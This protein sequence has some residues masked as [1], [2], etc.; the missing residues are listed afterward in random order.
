MMKRIIGLFLTTLFFVLAFNSAQAENKV[1]LRIGDRYAIDNTYYVELWADVAPS[2]E[3]IFG[4]EEIYLTFNNLALDP[5]TYGYAW[6]G[7]PTDAQRIYE[8]D[9]DLTTSDYQPYFQAVLPSTPEFTTNQ[10]YFVWQTIANA[11]DMIVKTGSFKIGTFRFGIIN[12]SLLDNISIGGTGYSGTQEASFIV[13]GYDEMTYNCGNSTCWAKIDPTPQYI[14]PPSP[15]ITTGPTLTSI[16][17]GS[18]ISVPFTTPAE[19]N[20]ANV[21]TAQLSD[22]AGSFATPTTIG[23]LTGIGSATIDANIPAAT[24]AGIAY[25][26]R[27]VGSDPVNIGIDNGTD[28]TIGTYPEQ[29]DLVG[30]E[31]YCPG[32]TGVVLT[33][34]NSQTGVSY[35]LTQDGTNYGAAIDGTGANILWNNLLVGNYNVVATSTSGC[36]TNMTAEKIVTNYILPTEFTLN[37]TDGTTYCPGG[38]SLPLELMGSEVGVNYQLLNNGIEVGLPINGTGSN[39]IWNVFAGTYTVEAENVATGC[40]RLF[41]TVIEI[42]ENVLPLVFPVSASATSYCAN[43]DGVS[44]TLVGSEVDVEYS[45]MMGETIVGDIFLGD[46]QSHT[47]TGMTA[48]SYQVSGLN[49]T[50]TCSR[51]MNTTPLVIS[52]IPLPTATIN[53]PLQVIQNSQA[54]YSTP[55]INGAEYLWIVTGG[56]ISGASNTANITVNW[57]EI[58]Q[59][60]IS[61]TKT[62]N[63]CIDANTENINI[64]DFQVPSIQA[65]NMI[66]LGIT[67]TNLTARWTRGNGNANILVCYPGNVID[68]TPEIGTTY[69]VGQTIGSGTV[70]YV[71]TGR[72][73]SLT[74]LT[75]G[76]TYTFKAFEYLT[77]GYYLLTNA[78]FNPRSKNT[79]PAVPTLNT[80][81]NVTSNSVDLSWE[82]TGSLDYYE[83]E[84]ATDIAFTEIVNGWQGADLGDMSY[85]NVDELEGNTQYYYRVR[86]ISG[87][88]ASAWVSGTFSTT[89][90][91]PTILPT[92]MQFADITVQSMNL[93]WTAGNGQYYLVIASMNNTPV[94]SPVDGTVYTVGDLYDGGTII[95]NGA[96]LTALAADLDPATN[97]YYTVFTYNGAAAAANYNP[98][99]LL[100]NHA[101]LATEPTLAPDAIT[102]EDITTTSMN[103]NWTAGNG[104]SYILIGIRNDG[105]NTFAS[106]EDATYYTANQDFSLATAQLGEAK[107]L[108]VGAN[109]SAL[110]S[111]LEANSEYMFRVYTFNGANETINVLDSYAEGI[112]VT[113]ENAPLT[114]PSDITFTNVTNSSFTVNFTQGSGTNTL[115]LMNINNNFTAPVS[116]NS[117]AVNSLIGDGTVVYNGPESSFDLNALS[118]DDRFYFQAFSYNGTGVLSNYNLTPAEGDVSTLVNEPTPATNM[119]FSNVMTN[120]MNVGWTNGTSTQYLVLVNSNPI[121]TAPIDGDSYLPGE[122]IGTAR[123][124]SAGTANPVIS[125]LLL[126]GNMYFYA[127]YAFD[128]TQGT[129][130]YSAAL[131]GQQLS[132]YHE[133]TEIPTNIVINNATTNSLHVEFDKAVG[134]QTI[135]VAYTTG[136]PTAPTDGQ[137]YDANG[138]FTSLLSSVIGNG[139]VVYSGHEEEFT[140]TGL[141]PNTTYYVAAYS[142]AGGNNFI[143]YNPNPQIAFAPTLLAEPTIA[144]TD[145]VFSNV[146]YTSMDLAWTPGNGTSSIVLMN[147]TNTFTAPIDGVSYIVDD[148]IGNASVVYNGTNSTLSLSELASGSTYYFQVYTFNGNADLVNYLATPAL[149][150]QATNATVTKLVITDAPASISVGQTFNITVQ[151]LDITDNPAMPI[152]PIT[153][154]LTLTNGGGTLFGTLTGTIPT[155]QTSV[156]FTGLQYQNSTPGANITITATDL[157]AALI[158]DDQVI[159]LSVSAPSIQDRVILFSGVTANS[160]NLAWT[161]G[162]ATN[163]IVVM[164]AGSAVDFIPQAN[165]SYPVSP[166]GV[167][168]NSNNYVIYNNTGNACPSPVLNAG[169]T[170][171]FRVFGYNQSGTSIAYNTL[172]GGFNP[173]NK[174]TLLTKDDVIPTDELN[175]N[176]IN[177][178]TFNISAINPNPVVNQINFRMTNYESMPMTFAVYDASG[179]EIAVLLSNQMQTKGNHDFSFNLDNNLSSGS[180]LLVVS[181]GDQFAVQSFV[182]VK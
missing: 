27:V 126:P 32:G 102:F 181:A 164:K 83:F 163:R 63:G 112:Q 173:R 133:P 49:F 26:I 115:V 136:E 162:N 108:Y 120:S 18:D 3:W 50:T 107:V 144:P 143:N 113:M 131:L 127:V 87:F 72:Q 171:H 129:E 128:G 47:W 53:G 54:N 114:P 153:V 88:T 74:N 106:P 52:E 31:Q 111:G 37:A 105:F 67:T 169:T 60:T 51:I 80:P 123:V 23:T 21:F 176:D 140:L 8:C 135:F 56:T 34:P 30:D 152:A 137:V 180:Y 142:Y 81:E 166:I 29:R 134:T 11:E 170:Y 104:A 141:T 61:L 99:G 148:L 94:I 139:K 40:R 45:I 121:F 161:L 69:T 84:L 103:V 157:L 20:A 175:E 28:I 179:R 15:S 155:N 98:T 156:T 65:R 5:L 66:F 85:V 9:P 7:D 150:Q 97:Y 14:I 147:T 132:M 117:Y 101:T 89:E 178:N 71:G 118:A 75:P 48:G 16:C 86:V 130:N 95:Y 33:L 79:I 160:M 13:N 145:I 167:G 44:I 10:A 182:I 12:G 124:L 91:E 68:G 22:A 57:G 4:A 78:S 38:N 159:G 168:V 158:G 119:I 62:A 122:F 110:I 146:N 165:T 125:D 55:L 58:G 109:T 42:S 90:S 154:N 59:G 100:G 17:V 116:G 151:A 24:P 19:F 93:S 41:E 92:N 35:Q 138:D 177:N 1:T 43:T 70:V 39:L 25:R 73:V 6:V 64:V 76:E 172:A 96:N 46:G 2:Q 149:G 82:Y 174:T 77:G 36:I